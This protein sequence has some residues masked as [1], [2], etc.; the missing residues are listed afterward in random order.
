MI[1]KINLSQ[2]FWNAPKKS[3]ICPECGEAQVLEWDSVG[4]GRNITLTS[5]SHEECYEKY[6][7]NIQESRLKAVS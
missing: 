4:D 1:L 3:N 7:K 2:S 5:S 6:R